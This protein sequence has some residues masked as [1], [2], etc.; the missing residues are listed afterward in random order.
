M[1]VHDGF[2]PKWF[3][4]FITR[5]DAEEI[6]RE[7][8]LGCFLIRLSDKAIAYI[9][10]YKG[11]DRCRHFVINQSESGKFLVCGDTAGH[12]TLSELIN[13]YRTKPI[14]PFGEHLTSSCVELPNE[15]LYDIIQEK[16][17]DAVRAVKNQQ[18]QQNSALKPPPTR[19]PRNNRPG[20]APPVPP[21]SRQVESSVWSDQER[22]LYA[23]LSKQASKETQRLQPC[24][25][26]L[27]GHDQRTFERSAPQLQ[28]ARRS[29][30]LS[31]PVSIYTELGQDGRSRSLPLLDSSSDRGQSHCLS[32]HAHTPPRRSPRPVR[33]PALSDAAPE[34][35][36]CT[37][38]SSGSGLEQASGAAVYHLA[39][40]PGPCEA[41]LQQQ[42][43]VVYTE[44]PDKPNTLSRGAESN[45]GMNTYEPVEDLRPRQKQACW[46]L[47]NDK[48]K[49]P[50]PE[51]K[52]KW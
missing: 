6:L 12:D 13:Y 36:L 34:A 37:G 48:W 20:G 43:D 30:P 44:V 40:S 25:D 29:S 18:N 22:L 2:F 50:F 46:G 8:E 52:R 3:L 41:R 26:S 39:G 10:S 27:T 5:K 38:S 9:L 24:R 28:N 21:R 11:K 33:Q 23:Q 14:E 15:E 19:P 45:P 42:E 17:L 4:G 31:Q 16:P 51:V 32:T 1:I 7:K 47:K 35:A 49:W